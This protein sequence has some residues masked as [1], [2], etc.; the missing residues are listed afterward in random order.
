MK[1]PTSQPPN[2][3]GANQRR[4]EPEMGTLPAFQQ[5]QLSF[6]R[7]LRDPRSTPRPPGV[8]AR[9]AAVYRTLLSNN[10]EGFLLACFPVCRAV[11]GERRWRRLM[12]A[13]FRDARCHSPYFRDIPHEFLSW[14]MKSLALPA[15]LPPWLTEL[16]HYEWVELALDVMEV[17]QAAALQSAPDDA[18]EPDPAA[19]IPVANPALMNLAYQWPVHRIG[20]QWRPRKPLPTHLAAYRDTRNIVRFMTLNAVSARL[21]ALVVE[22]G[23][24]GSALCQQIANELQHPRPAAVHAHG[25]ALLQQ[26]L[27]AEVIRG[28]AA[29]TVDTKSVGH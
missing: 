3:A 26:W 14:L 10:L 12:T 18:A 1:L 5:F 19:M 23:R 6:A 13:F 15:G 25:Q 24:T 2:S 9:R 11:L 16:A 17:P 22:G 20:L 8:D 29:P 21:L 4:P 7:H 28:Y 27:V